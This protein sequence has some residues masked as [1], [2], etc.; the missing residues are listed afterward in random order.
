MASLIAMQR[1]TQVAERRIVAAV[2]TIQAGSDFDL[3]EPPAYNR[4]RDY[5]AVQRTEWIADLLDALVAHVGAVVPATASGDADAGDDTPSLEWSRKDL[6]AH[7]ESL[8]IEKAD[9][10]GAKP[11]ILE[12]IEAKQAELDAAAEAAESSGTAEPQEN[13][14][15]GTLDQQVANVDAALGDINQPPA[16]SEPPVQE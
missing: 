1:R 10:L 9:K 6:V 4:D 5:A 2:T 12:A 7:A 15:A 13:P 8:G 16:P 11:V 14:D 3:P